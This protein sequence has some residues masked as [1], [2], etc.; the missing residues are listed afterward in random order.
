MELIRGVVPPQERYAAIK[1]LAGEGHSVQL[2]CRILAVAESGYYD[3]LT[4]AP[5]VRAIGHALLLDVIRD[6]HTASRGVYGARRVTAELVLGRGITVGHGR[7]ELLMACD[8]LKG[9]AARPK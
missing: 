9:V 3:W 6:V 2:C 5:S 1:Q 4:R 8:G 7:V